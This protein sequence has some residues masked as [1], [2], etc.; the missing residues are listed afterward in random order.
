M[1][2]ICHH[3]YE[4]SIYS[5]LLRYVKFHKEATRVK[6]VDRE[7][8]KDSSEVMTYLSPHVERLL[9]PLNL[10]TVV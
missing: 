6:H 1:R 5:L 4:K 7:Q 3:S 10:A 9:H 2:N 8:K